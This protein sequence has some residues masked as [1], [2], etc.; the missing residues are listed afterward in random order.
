MTEYK[1]VMVFSHELSYDEYFRSSLQSFGIGI[2]DGLD[3]RGLVRPTNHADLSN[4]VPTNIQ[5]L[6]IYAAW[7]VSEEF[8]GVI[9]LIRI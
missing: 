6:K 3:N 5:A 7:A 4:Q 1:K 9:E 8:S 2:A